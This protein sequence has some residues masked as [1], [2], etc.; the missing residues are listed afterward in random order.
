MANWNSEKI[1][2]ALAD[3]GKVSI[4]EAGGS[5]DTDQILVYPTG[6]DNEWISVTGF[7]PSKALENEER[8]NAENVG[9]AE[10]RT[11]GDSSGGLQSKNENVKEAY[12]HIMTRMWDLGFTIINHYDEIF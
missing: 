10:V 11:N 1:K 2:I 12:N 6:G 3:L 5:Y 8:S 9:Y 4:R 7:R